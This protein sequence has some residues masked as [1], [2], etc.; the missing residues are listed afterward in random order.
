M[1]IASAF[2]ER[3]QELDGRID[4]FQPDDNDED[5]SCDDETDFVVLK[6]WQTVTNPFL[7]RDEETDEQSER[8]GIDDSLDI[9]MLPAG[10]LSTRRCEWVPKTPQ[11]FCASRIPPFD[12]V[13]QSA[14]ALGECML[15]AGFEPASQPRE[16]RILDRARLQER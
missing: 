16:G 11:R 8:D 10:S 14:F 7:K 13:L 15:P 12:C 2:W 3:P 4:D 1:L 6:E 9:H 5:Y